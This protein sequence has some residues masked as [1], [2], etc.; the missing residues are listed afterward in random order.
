MEI[1]DIKVLRGPNYWSNYRTNLIEMQLDLDI[2]ESL[3]TDWLPGFTE[4]LITLLPGLLT[5]RCSPGYEG[6]FLERLKEGTWLGHVVEHVALEIQCM[7]G[8]ECGFGRTRSTGTKG[9]YNVVFSYLNENAGRYAAVAAVKFIEALATQCRY[10]I[11]ADI[12]HLKRIYE[13][14]QPGPSTAA[15]IAEARRRDIPVTCLDRGSLYVLGYGCNQKLIR[16]AIASTTSGIGIDIVGD[17]EE[18]KALLA[19]SFIPVPQGALVDSEFLLWKAVK[20]LGFPLTIKPRDGNHGRAVTTNITDNETAFEAYMKAGK[21]SSSVIVEPYISGNDY[22][23]LVVNHK[24]VAAARRIPAMVIGDG[25]STI[26]I[27]V[28]K[29]NSNP[30]RGSGHNKSLTFIEIDDTSIS[31][32]KRSGLNP[33]TVLKKGQIVYLKDSANLSSGGTAI[34]VTEELHPDNI[35]L[36]ERVSRLLHMD[37]CG[38]DIICKDMGQP[39]KHTGGAVI[40]VNACPGL[41]MHLNPSSGSGRNVAAP[42]VSLLF[43]EGSNAR[44]PLVAVT[45][46]NGKTTTARLIAHLA[47]QQGHTVGYTTTDGIY[48]DNQVIKYGDCSGPLSAQVILREPSVSFAV[49]ECARGGMLRAGLGFDHCN[50]SVVTNVSEDHLGI[51]GIESLE[52]MA[53]VKAIVPRSTFAGGYA[54]LNADDPLV[55]NMQQGLDCNIALFSTDGNAENITRHIHNGGLAAY[56]DSRNIILCHNKKRTYLIATN[57]VPLTFGGTSAFMIKNVLA[58]VLAAYIAGCPLPEIT[59][60]LKSFLPSPEMTPGRMNEFDFGHFKLILDYM[61]NPAGFLEVSRFLEKKQARRKIGI[62]SATGD[63]REKDIILLGRYSA[64]MFDEV[65]INNDHDKR[66][67]SA[68]ELTR[69]LCQGVEN[70]KPGAKIHIAANERSAIDYALQQAADGD[71]IFAAIDNVFET[72]DYVKSCLANN[73]T[74]SAQHQKLTL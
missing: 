40:E 43:P 47:M 14:A 7:A 30:L 34:D 71:L 66:G 33:G 44:I 63:R 39:V 12:S 64:E 35:R 24:V 58:A 15:I 73:K 23:V 67:R 74:Q 3:P 49:L 48:L 5:H 38:I 65:I 69:L 62:L 53:E 10:D 29:E 59:Q 70:K 2:F 46:T 31:L 16:A 25:V 45:G 55:F 37:I 41:R 1:L 52:Q 20:Q 36:A 26:E 11:D 27:L 42:I 9:I 72:L 18:T 56:T 51:G 68:E 54:V 50:V 13:E 19:R 57:A 28:N 4:D 8:M 21:F 32:L 60:G 61:H 6:G 17:K 22:R